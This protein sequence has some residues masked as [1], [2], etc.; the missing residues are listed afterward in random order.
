VTVLGKAVTL[1]RQGT[2]KVRVNGCGEYGRIFFDRR[3]IIIF[4]AKIQIIP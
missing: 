1:L 3:L 4:M 2:V